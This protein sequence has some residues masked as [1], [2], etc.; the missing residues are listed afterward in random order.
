MTEFIYDFGPTMSVIGFGEKCE[1]I[2]YNL[3]YY[4]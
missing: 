1:L 3:I 4:A 2:N